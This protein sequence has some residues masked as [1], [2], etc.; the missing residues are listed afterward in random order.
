MV[1]PS[2]L[3]YAQKNTTPLP[4]DG[5][6]GSSNSSEAANSP[7][8][9]ATPQSLPSPTGP[10]QIAPS[11]N[12]AESSLFY[13][14]NMS[15]RPQTDFKALTSSQRAKFYLHGLLGPVM[16]LSAATSAGITQAMDIPESWG[17][18]AEGY[19]QRFGNYFAKQAVQRSLR[20]AGEEMLHEDNRYFQSGE[21]G[22]VRRIAYA[23][24]SSVMARGTDG[25]Q[26]LSISGIG[27]IAGASFISRLWQPPGNN[28]AGDGAVSFGIGMGVNA[29]VHILREFLP[30]ATRRIFRR[31][32]QTSRP[33]TTPP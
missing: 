13:F 8:A 16:L 10:S 7:S 27:S 19:G 21:H 9:G 28:S 1:A 22:L 25:T 14:L 17:Q 29:G 20:L 32:Q 24:K 5:S 12:R 23:L 18:D 6:A 31:D 30:D 2:T 26:H 3:V 4:A 33:V 11:T 15:G